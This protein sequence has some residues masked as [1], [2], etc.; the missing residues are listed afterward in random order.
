MECP[1]S[2]VDRQHFPKVHHAGSNPVWDATIRLEIALL[3]QQSCIFGFGL[4]LATRE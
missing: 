3:D 2:L 4:E 1:S